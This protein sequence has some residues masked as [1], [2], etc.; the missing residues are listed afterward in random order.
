MGFCCLRVLQSAEVQRG[1]GEFFT[2]VL[3][4]E[5]LLNVEPER[6]RVNW[7]TRLER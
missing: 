7:G 1:G 5:P 6:S 2:G 4:V 3:G